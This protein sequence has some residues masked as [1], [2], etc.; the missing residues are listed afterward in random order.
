M[1]EMSLGLFYQG[2]GRSPAA[3]RQACVPE[4][5]NSNFDHMRSLAR[6][7]EAALFD[8][9]FIADT[10]TPLGP[11][12][13]AYW[14]H[15]TGIVRLDPM[16]I[17]AHVSPVTEKIGWI[18]TGSTMYIEPYLLARS[19][20]TM[21][22]ANGGRTGWNIVTSGNA[23]EARN[24]GRD[25]SEAQHDD[26]YVRAQE[27]ADVAMK[28]WDTFAPDA[29]VADRA[30][31]L[32]FAPDRFKLIE[33][34]G[35]YFSVRGPLTVPRSP[36][37]RPV[38]VSAGQSDAGRELA[39][40]NSEVVFAVQQD[41]KDA[42]L[43]YADMKQRA[44]RYG[45]SPSDIKIMPGL[46]PFVAETLDEARRK[47]EYSQSLITPEFGVRALSQ[48][49][50][51]FDLTRFPIDGPLPELPPT[52][53]SQGRQ[54]VVVNLA[55]RD[56]LTIRQLYQ[57]ISGE[58]GHLTAVGTPTMIADVMEEWCSTGAADGFNV[59]PDVLPDGFSEFVRLVL[60]ELRRRGLFR[61]KYRGSTLR[62]NLGLS[63]PKSQWDEPAAAG[64]AD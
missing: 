24:F 31:G 52:T 59:M 63:W 60:P 46:V 51:G 53:V 6:A 2:T 21:E 37:G 7:A 35:K 26:K 3:W 56:N 19:L 64:A 45:R 32:Y 39:G 16:V 49:V 30:K 38:I 43:M 8:F 55:R 11:D 29:F 61:K 9:I 13:L 54:A 58:N 12:D 4:N 10:F 1:A 50:G 28:L 42:R 57:M 48:M 17:A 47:R 33:H 25:P 34:K 5:P 20:A 27:Y 44:A 14:Q 15:T 41:I 22:I 18:V 40:R 62:E 36:Q 23:A